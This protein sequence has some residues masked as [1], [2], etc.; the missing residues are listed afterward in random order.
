MLLENYLKELRVELD[1]AGFQAILIKLQEAINDDKMIFLCGNG[2]SGA[3]ASHFANDLGKLVAFESGRKVKAISLTADSAVLTTFGND[4][5]YETIFR[6]QLH[7]IGRAGDVMV[8]FSGSG[9][10]GNVIRAVETCKREGI[11]TIGLTGA[12]KSYDE[13]ILANLV[14]LPFVVPSQSMQIIEDIHLIL[15][16]ALCMGLIEALR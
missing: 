11:Y 1:D 10:S 15:T 3:T 12:I 4:C 7:N 8:A 13:N 14:D 9:Q 5:G 16:H 6:E 2:G